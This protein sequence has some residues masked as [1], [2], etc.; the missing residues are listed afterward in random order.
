MEEPGEDLYGDVTE[1]ADIEII[2]SSEIITPKS[3]ELRADH[4]YGGIVTLK[5]VEKNLKMEDM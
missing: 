3:K 5:P 4:E 1:S 2:Q